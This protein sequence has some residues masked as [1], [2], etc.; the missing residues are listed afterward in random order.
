MTHRRLIR[1]ALPGLF[2]A[3]AALVMGLTSSSATA[4]TTHAN[5]SQSIS[6]NLGVNSTSPADKGPPGYGDHG[7]G[8][9]D[10]D[11]G[12]HH[13]RGWHECPGWWYDGDWY[14]GS[15]WYWGSDWFQCPG[16]WYIYGGHHGHHHHHG[17][18]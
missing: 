18:F 14:P 6:A 7:P 3:T 17:G 4:A 1:L 11:R 5:A 16:W 9:G 2:I 10:H 15:G 12:W 13:G 8:W